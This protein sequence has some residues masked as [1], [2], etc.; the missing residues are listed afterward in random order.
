MASGADTC[1]VQGSGWPAAPG[2]GLVEGAGWCCAHGGGQ[3]EQQR[4]QWPWRWR[5]GCGRARGGSAPSGAGQVWEGRADPARTGPESRRETGSGGGGGG[6]AAGPQSGREDDRSAAGRGQCWVAREAAGLG[7]EP[8]TPKAPPRRAS[9]AVG[10]ARSRELRAAAAPVV[11]AGRTRAGQQRG[12]VKGR[13]RDA[14]EDAGVTSR[15]P[16]RVQA[17]QLGIPGRRSPTAPGPAGDAQV[18]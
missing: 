4:R 6:G 12:D 18:R 1:R 9:G 5:A 17:E 16:G 10:R 15:G 7:A 2:V 11:S 3:G 13:R 14:R 8:M